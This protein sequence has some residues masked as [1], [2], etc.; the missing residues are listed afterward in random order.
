MQNRCAKISRLC[1][2]CFKTGN[3]ERS[4]RLKKGNKSQIGFVSSPKQLPS[5]GPGRKYKDSS[6]R[7]AV[8]V[9]VSEG[10]SHSV[11]SKPVRSRPKSISSSSAGSH[12]L[13]LWVYT[14]SARIAIIGEINEDE[15]LSV[16]SLRDA[17]VDNEDVV[18]M[19]C[20]LPVE[21]TKGCIA[22]DAR[23][24]MVMSQHADHVCSSKQHDVENTCGTVDGDLFV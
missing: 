1:P 19:E 10:E 13:K 6:A 22:V 8:S 20:E 23:E 11:V 14:G 17:L 2:F 4:V 3:A 21:Y 16:T 5:H 15:L 12:Q 7:D 18:M 9:V 24:S